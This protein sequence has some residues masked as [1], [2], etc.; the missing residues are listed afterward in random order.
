MIRIWIFVFLTVSVL[1]GEH[2]ATTPLARTDADWVERNAAL[3]ALSKTS[4]AQL[5][6]LGDSITQL[7][8]ADDAG[9]KVW[10]KYWAPLKAANFGISG[11]RTEHVLWRLNHGNLAG[12][13]PKLIVL[14]I[15]TN[16]AGQQE[17]EPNYK[18]S[19]QQTAQGIQAI[20][21]KLKTVCP[22]AKVLLLAIFPRGE[23]DTDKVRLQNDKVNAIISTFADGKRVHF[24]DIGSKFM[25]PN[26]DLSVVNMPDMLHLSTEGYSIWATAIKEKVS[27]LM[28]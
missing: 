8:E 25:K 2:V 5:V 20:L 12:M 28:K 26:G 23:E 15:G 21:E 11:D 27:E 13:R 24:M 1:A 18:C 22:T 17:E 6:F 3:N 9:K 19:P 14:M 7:W 10:E 16:N 4:D